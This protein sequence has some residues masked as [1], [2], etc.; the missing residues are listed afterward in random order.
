M[1]NVFIFYYYFVQYFMNYAEQWLTI[2]TKHKE[3]IKDIQYNRCY[4]FSGIV[5]SYCGG[6][7]GILYLCVCSVFFYFV[8]ILFS[9][10]GFLLN[11]CVFVFCL[12]FLFYL[13]SFFW[14]CCY[15]VQCFW[16]FAEQFFCDLF[17][18]FGVWRVWFCFCGI[19]LY[20]LIWGIVVV[21]LW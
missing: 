16:V 3:D 4:I 17:V 2:H 21:V 1:F 5:N 18:L 19:F 13:F 10:F 7:Y 6:F 9:V 15:F 8:V 11:S 14:F 12:F 20:C